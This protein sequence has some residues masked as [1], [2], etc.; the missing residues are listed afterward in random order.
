M[1][2]TY[3]IILVSGVSIDVLGQQKEK[4]L[5]GSNN[6]GSCI[7]HIHTDQGEAAVGD[8]A[9]RRLDSSGLIS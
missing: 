3:R 9:G 5:L 1:S 2:F 7:G 6:Q 4:K 8:R